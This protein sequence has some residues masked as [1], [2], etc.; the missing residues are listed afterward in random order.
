LLHKT[1]G[2]YFSCDYEAAAEAAEVAIRAYPDYPSPYRWLVAALGQVGRIEEAREA[3][4]KAIAIA[5]ASFDMNVRQ[6]APWMRLEDHAHMLEG[7]R[8]AGREG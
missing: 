1:T 7:L 6:R 2:L 8:K 4:E 5:P 3:L